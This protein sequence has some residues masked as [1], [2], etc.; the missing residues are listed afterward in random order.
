MMNVGPETVS[1]ESVDLILSTLQRLRHAQFS[2]IIVVPCFR[3]GQV[4]HRQDSSTQLERGRTT[5]R[6]EQRRGW[7]RD[8]GKP[9]EQERSGNSKGH[10]L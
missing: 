1:L 8:L 4:R 5:T 10:S 7:T 6:A 3:M 2:I 9:L